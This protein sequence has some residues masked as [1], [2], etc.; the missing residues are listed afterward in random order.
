MSG[1][2]APA[3]LWLSGTRPEVVRAGVSGWCGA[4]APERGRE[5]RNVEEMSLL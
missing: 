1:T 2:R 3:E 4:S 5:A